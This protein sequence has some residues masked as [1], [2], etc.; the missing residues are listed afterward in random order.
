[1]NRKIRAVIIDDEANLRAIISMFIERYLKD[2][3]VIGQANDVEE[4]VDLINEKAPDLIFLDVELTSGSG[5][6]IVRALGEITAKIIFV[7][8]HQHYAIKAINVGAS[9]YILKPLDIEEFKTVSTK[10]IKEITNSINASTAPEVNDKLIISV[11]NTVKLISK[12]Q[13]IHIQ[14][15]GSYSKI[16]LDDGRSFMMSKNLKYFEE[17]LDDSLFFRVHHSH[18]INLSKIS[19]YST[20]GG[21]IV[22]L[23]N[24]DQIPISRRK[25]GDFLLQIK[26]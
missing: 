18:L 25:K 16:H 14:A 26:G 2:V 6:D 4:G 1:M 12:K 19:E 15:E 23:L 22:H 21:D 17:L 3:E 7:T 8:S 10:V 11:G 13:I 5:F 20:K 24:G 9:G